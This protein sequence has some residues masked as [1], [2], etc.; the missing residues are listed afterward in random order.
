MPK[1]S[2]E[3]R[4]FRVAGILLADAAGVERSDRERSP[5]LEFCEKRSTPA[6]VDSRWHRF[7]AGVLEEAIVGAATGRGQDIILCAPPRHG[8]THLTSVLAPAWGIGEFPDLEVILTSYGASLAQD[9]SVD[10]RNLLETYGRH[11]F[12]IEIAQDRRSSARWRVAYHKGGMRA[13]GVGGPI[14]GRGANLGIIDDPIKNWE[15]AHS[16]VHRE[17]IWNWYRTTF[18]TR[19]EPGATTIIMLTRWHDD[20]LAGRLIREQGRVEDG[21]RWR[22]IRIPAIAEEQDPLGR[23]PG[24]A[25]WPERWSAAALEERRQ[26]LSSYEWDALFQQR[27]Q[28]ATGSLFKRKHFCYARRSTRPA[29]DPKDA[30]SMIPTPGFELDLRENGSEPEREWVREE[31]CYKIMSVDTALSL[32]KTADRTAIGVWAITPPIRGRRRRIL[33]YGECERME[34]PDQ[35]PRI[36]VLRKIHGVALVGIEKASAGLAAVQAA[37]RAGLPVRELDA[38]TDKVARALPAT[39]AYEAGDMFHLEGQPWLSDCE[40]EL[41]IFPR[42]AHDDWVDMVSHADHMAREGADLASQV[43]VPG[44]NLR[45]GSP[46]R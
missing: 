30:R 41:L 29:P 31:D 8:K 28:P 6:W 11:D 9:V 35:I 12:G 46:K 21:G 39:A 5:L 18:S 42:G 22:E 17:R 24:E 37:R 27:P 15:E 10:C 45:V 16:P 33:I 14:T 38:D 25:L 4:L 13:A 26:R 44:A 20:D 7:L 23:K 2:M 36:T 1:A 19:L 43:F 40:S 32:K 34:F 3:E